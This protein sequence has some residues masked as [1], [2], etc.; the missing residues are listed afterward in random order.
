MSHEKIKTFT[1][2]NGKIQ[3]TYAAS[4][5]RPLDWR[6][7]TE[8]TNDRNISGH[9][10]DLI[11]GVEEPQKSATRY[12]QFAQTIKL[13]YKLNKGP[14]DWI[15]DRK[16]GTNRD[17][18][19]LDLFVK[20][21]GLPLFRSSFNLSGNTIPLYAE[22]AMFE[23]ETARIYA[24]EETSYKARGMIHICSASY[25]DVLPGYDVLFAASGDSLFIA[26][27]E[28]YDSN[29][30]LNNSD[31]S[32]IQFTENDGFDL[33]ALFDFFS[34]SAGYASFTNEQMGKI[35][36][37]IFEKDA[38]LADTPLSFLLSHRNNLIRRTDR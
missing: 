9:I 35:Q 13:S 27:R 10:R 17:F 36:R 38:S 11:Q 34:T 29:G 16:Y 20:K 6:T 7:H 14:S 4:N 15:L 3:V 22:I 32:A 25:S 5:I 37:R 30:N 19:F 28:D 18:M 26:K 12:Y 2:K 31:D 33:N 24:K 8:E 21:V 1:L 23:E